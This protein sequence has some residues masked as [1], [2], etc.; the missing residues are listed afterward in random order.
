MRGVVTGLFI[1]PEKKA[2]LVSVEA[3][4]TNERGFAGDY[5]SAF[6]NN[7]QI[8][9]ISQSILNQFDLQPG[10]ISENVVVDGIDVMTLSE[11]QHLRMGTAVLEVTFPCE[12]CVHMERIRPGLKSALRDHRGMFAQVVTPGAIRIG[13]PVELS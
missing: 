7:R 4:R 10:A 13:D 2:K 6:T 12:P 11:G 3:V 5:H 9:I 8:L 1:A